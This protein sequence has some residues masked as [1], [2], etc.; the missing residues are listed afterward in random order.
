MATA[1]LRVTA[2]ISWSGRTSVWRNRSFRLLWTGQATSQLGDRIHQVALL[3]WAVQLHGRAVDASWVLVASSLPLAVLTPIA[4]ALADRRDRRRLML[5]CDAGRA[6]LVA[7]LAALAALDRLTL[8]ILI[9][10]TLLLSCLAAVFAPAVLAYVPEVV[11]GDELARAGSLQE[12]TAQLSGL[13][14]PAIGGVLVATVGTKAAFGANSVSFILSAL[15][16]LAIRPGRAAMPSAKV[17]GRL[18]DE[19]RAGWAVARD[20]P[21]IGWLLAAFGAANLFFSPVPLILPRLAQGF[22]VGARGF[23]WLEGALAL[24]MFAGSLA[25]A[26]RPVRASAKG[27]RDLEDR[28]QRRRAAICI[29][30]AGGLLLALAA[31]SRFAW[32]VGILVLMGAALATLNVQVMAYFQLAVPPDRLGRFMGLLMAIVFAA[33]PLGFALSGWLVDAWSIPGTLTLAGGAIIAIG[34]TLTRP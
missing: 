30:I 12:L 6:I 19:L 17:P 8:P 1:P 34:L 26:L 15:A 13:V 27:S 31:G 29:S 7:G 33:Q 2:P 24:G 23:G 28:D 16:L 32:A 21:T 25:I 9:V 4:G 18:W 11:G 5:A 14:G 22:H 10:T 3:W 20:R